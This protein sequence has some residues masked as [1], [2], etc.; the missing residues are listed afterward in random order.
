MGEFVAESAIKQMILAKQNIN[1]SKVL[2]LGITFKENCPDIRNTKVM[3]VVNKLKEYDLDIDVTDAIANADEVFKE[4][5]VKL[6]RDDMLGKYDCIILAVAHDKYRRFTI[7]NYKKLINN[8]NG[9]P[10]IIDIKG[11]LSKSFWEDV[12]CRYWRL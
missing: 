11:I 6:V 5:N 2:V 10:V 12:D 7:E 4:Y 3:D 8:E 1:N 9:C